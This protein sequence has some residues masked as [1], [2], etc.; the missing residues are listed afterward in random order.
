VNGEL[1]SNG[2]VSLSRQELIWWA[3]IILLIGGLL[4]AGLVH[5]L[6]PA[7]PGGA[8]P[9]TAPLPVLG[10]VSDFSLIDSAGEPVSRDDLGGRVWVADFFFT[11][12][13]G[14][15]P[16]MSK[17][18]VELQK[19]L[20][21]VEEV[22]LV[23][24]SV[25]PERDTPERLRRYAKQYGADPVRWWFLTGDK[26]AIFRLSQESFHL[27]VEDAPTEDREPDMEDV[28]H[29]SKF[30]LL[31]RDARI[32]GYY[33]GEDPATVAQLAADIRWLLKE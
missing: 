1:E 11:S 24:I 27:G 7:R 29:S 2:A 30:V 8:V 20:A 28:L 19:A 21:G 15:C 22:T 4:G 9:R 17:R 3:G 13:A 25:D 23:S 14:I 6:Q 12:C 5:L 26:R 10:Q 18:L 33:D 16:M 31:D 32:R